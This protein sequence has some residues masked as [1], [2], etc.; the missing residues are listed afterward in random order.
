M[1]WNVVGYPLCFVI[2]VF[3][4]RYIWPK[5]ESTLKK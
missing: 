1:D 4:G 5:V 2:G 3:L